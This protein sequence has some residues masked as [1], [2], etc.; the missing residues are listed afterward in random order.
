VFGD[1][2]AYERFMGRWSAQLAPLYLDA[3]DLPGPSRV[4]D[5]GTGTGNL[6]RAVA[7]RW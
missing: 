7:Q 1:A 4:L 6:A 5:V 3:V 2:K